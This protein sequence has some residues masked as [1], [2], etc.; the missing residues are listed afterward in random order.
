MEKIQPIEN[1]STDAYDIYLIRV[2]NNTLEEIERL[3]V[4][5][6][7]DLE[8]VGTLGGLQMALNYTT[9]YIAQSNGD[10][11]DIIRIRN[12]PY[13][14]V[15]IIPDTL[16]DTI[17]VSDEGDIQLTDILQQYKNNTHYIAEQTA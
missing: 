3:K 6:W 8:G 12:D 5:T 9:S 16:V 1:S 17:D 10:K 4:W 14:E 2:D 13:T 11:L 7:R 15:H